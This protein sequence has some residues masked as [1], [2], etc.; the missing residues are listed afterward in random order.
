MEN[1]LRELLSVKSPSE[2]E[3]LLNEMYEAYLDKWG[4]MDADLSGSHFVKT[5]LI[6]IVH[7]MSN[8]H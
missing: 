6:E 3:D 1:T 7:N 2:I 4:M 8:D 5:K